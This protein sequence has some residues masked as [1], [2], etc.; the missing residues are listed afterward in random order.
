VTHQPEETAAL[1]VIA[2]QASSGAKTWSSA[3]IARVR[4]LS[5]S[6]SYF[7]DARDAA[8]PLIAS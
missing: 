8:S 1:F 3:R 2:R 5:G 7:V 4:A 6:V